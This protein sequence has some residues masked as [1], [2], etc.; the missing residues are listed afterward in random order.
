LS[1]FIFFL[2]FLRKTFVIGKDVPLGALMRL[3]VLLP[4]V[5]LTINLIVAVI[6]MSTYI[7]RFWNMVGT[8]VTKF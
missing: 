8:K 2:I 3:T 4:S 7:L 1:F 5:I 6:S